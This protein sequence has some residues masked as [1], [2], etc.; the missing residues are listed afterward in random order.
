MKIQR[1]LRRRRKKRKK[2]KRIEI[3][4]CHKSLDMEMKK[5]AM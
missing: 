4:L 3:N 5:K 1:K 2:E